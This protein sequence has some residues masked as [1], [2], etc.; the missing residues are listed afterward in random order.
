QAGGSNWITPEKV[1]EAI[2]LVET[3]KIYELGHVYEP[4]MPVF[5]GRT[6]SLYIPSF[7]TGGTLG[8]DLVYNDELVVGEI[9]QVGTQFD[10]PGHVG[11]RVTAEDGTVEHIFYNGVR[12]SEMKGAYGLRKLGV[13]HVGPYVTRG[14][15]IDVAGYKGVETLPDRYVV[16]LEDVR[17]ALEA[18]GMSEE[19]IRP[20]DAVLFNFGWWRLWPDPKVMSAAWPGIGR[21]VADWIVERGASMVGSDAATDEATE[22]AV[23]D[24][25]TLKHGIFNLELMNFEE[26]LQDGV[27]EF[28]FVFTPLRLKGATGSPGRPLAIR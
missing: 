10:G 15:L 13:E 1:L 2:Q 26:L 8:P 17:G 28:M 27:H 19:D 24:E 11:K 16:T 22:W 18:Q 25:L 20:G 4:G 14:V 7:P 9:G 3:G 23:H 21:P 6:Y 5:P 12:G